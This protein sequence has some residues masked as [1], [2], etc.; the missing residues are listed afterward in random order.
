VI[1]THV[2][3]PDVEL[4][5]VLRQ[6]D[7]ESSEGAR[8]RQ[9]SAFDNIAGGF[10]DRLVLFGAGPLG[11][12]I[13]TGLR[14]AGLEPI[15][16]AD[17]NQKLWD[18]EISGLR[19]LPPDEAA[20]V[21]GETACFVVTIY[22]GSSVRHQL[23]S[24]R[25]QRI[26]PFV[27]LLWKYADIFIPQS[28]IELPNRLLEQGEALRKCHGVLADDIS[29][30][31][32]CEQ[33]RWRYWLDYA[34]LSPPFDA[35]NT[36]FPMDLLSPTAEEVFVDCGGFDGDTIRSFNEHWGS[37][38][39]HAFALEPDPVN[40]AALASNI[41]A[42][43]LTSRLT[44]MPYVV[45]SATGSV[46]FANT[47]SAA[48]H[49]T[50]GDRGIT[51]ECRRLDDIDWSLPPTYIKMDIEGAEPEALAGASE[52]LH[53]HHPVL[54]VCTYHRSEHLWQIPNLIRSIAPEYNVFLRRY[55]EE[56]W[57]GVCYA[58]P[59]QRLKRS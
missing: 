41:E 58:I 14:Q 5:N 25:C 22:Q 52:L 4:E 42:M 23:A 56:C 9:R 12:G 15:A 53:R 44:I 35:R 10:H 47:S 36:Y 8:E 17:N 57:E 39:R 16:F 31:E 32:L 28:G 26:S 3:A 2:A 37:R 24:L 21:Y 20:R 7:A 6:M 46:S 40:R 49:V 34:A 11:K 45:G 18:K 59:N 13:L 43:G 55:A 27:A 19:V 29:K 54:A 1:P 30:R 38:F 50:T 33:L 48:S 51:V